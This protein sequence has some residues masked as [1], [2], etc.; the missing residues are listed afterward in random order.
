MTHDEFKNALDEIL[1]ELRDMLIDKNLKYG[2][3][4]LL[5]CRIFAK[6]DAV[7]QINVRIDDKLNRIKNQAANEDEDAEFD[8]MGY[9]LLKR[10]LSFFNNRK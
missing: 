3:S 5:P 8:L 9:L 2:N 1:S 7:E 6:S 4:A 10:A